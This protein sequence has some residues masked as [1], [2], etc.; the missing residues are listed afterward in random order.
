M[1]EINGRLLP[2]MNQVQAGL[3]AEAKN[4]FESETKGV[5]D[6]NKVK[7]GWE[8]IENTWDFLFS[9]SKIDDRDAPIKKFG[10]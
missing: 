7:E 4:Y 9:Q 1:K 5:I 10:L 8:N 2:S 3:K 6:E